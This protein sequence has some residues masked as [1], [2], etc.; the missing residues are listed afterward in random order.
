MRHLV[1]D[2]TLKR[3]DQ[4]YAFCQCVLKYNL[5]HLII[6]LSLTD[7]TSTS[8]S[9]PYGVFSDAFAEVIEK[10]INLISLS[11]RRATHRPPEG[12]KLDWNAAALLTMQSR[13][14]ETLRSRPP[15]TLYVDGAN[16]EVLQVLEGIEGI[17]NLSLGYDTDKGSVGES[18]SITLD[19]I[20]RPLSHTLYTL[21][22]GL[23][24]LP[25]Y[26]TLSTPPVSAAFFQ[27][28]KVHT[29]TLLGNGRTRTSLPRIL[30]AFPNLKRL[31]LNSPSSIL[32]T[33][34]LPESMFEEDMRLP[35]EALGGTMPG[36]R[37]PMIES[38]SADV[39]ILKKYGPHWPSLRFLNLTSGPW[40]YPSNSFES[41]VEVL[42]GCP[43][44]ALIL[45]VYHTEKTSFFSKLADVLPKVR[46][47]ELRTKFVMGASLQESMDLVSQSPFL[48]CSQR[49]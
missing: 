24:R 32:P 40:I 43:I 29:L 36:V 22:L 12:Q 37:G 48:R 5:C 28:P 20:V 17:E 16:M 10:A 34:Q 41:C 30:R 18:Q 26:L 1:Q 47:L 27:C 15:T 25:H 38:L 8:H 45:T 23:T 7:G 6:R 46:Y 14:S 11:F 35:A 2:V 19:N 42:S 3:R 39:L 21:S 4:A 44:E 13:I 33:G 49:H 9:C 31:A